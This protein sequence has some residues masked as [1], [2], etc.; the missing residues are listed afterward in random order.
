M[1]GSIPP[2]TKPR[3]SG[4][5]SSGAMCSAYS[6]HV[7][8]Q[9][10]WLGWKIFSL[11]I[12]SLLRPSRAGLLCISQGRHSSTYRSTNICGISTLCQA[13]TPSHS[14]LSVIVGAWETRTGD[15]L[16]YSEFRQS[17]SL[18]TLSN[19]HYLSKSTENCKVS[20]CCS[21]LNLSCIPTH[22]C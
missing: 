20:F 17:I 2:L 18:A 10:G 6:E 19:S 11:L 16:S 12:K 9:P 5:P 22:E 8:Q 4:S 13:T 7:S 15:L 21:L 14:I 1:T 3:D